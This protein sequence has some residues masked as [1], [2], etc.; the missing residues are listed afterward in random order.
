MIYSGLRRR[1]RIQSES[2]MSVTSTESHRAGRTQIS[3][4]LLSCNYPHQ[5][6][7]NCERQLI[8]FKVSSSVDD[9]L[10]NVSDTQAVVHKRTGTRKASNCKNADKLTKS[11]VMMMVMRMKGKV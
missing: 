1:D 8:D 5:N 4:R 11:D 6:Q 2:L 9:R 7:S 10:A 3:D